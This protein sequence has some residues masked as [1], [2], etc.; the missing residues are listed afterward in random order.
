[1]V[2]VS[3]FEFQIGESALYPVLECTNSAKFGVAERTI[4]VNSPPLDDVYSGNSGG[5][6]RSRNYSRPNVWG[7]GTILL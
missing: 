6:A 3:I 1:M 2:N 5:A 4:S 7:W